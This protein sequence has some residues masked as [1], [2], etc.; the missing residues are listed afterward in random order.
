MPGGSSRTEPEVRY[1]WIPR[2]MEGLVNLSFCDKRFERGNTNNH[3]QIDVSPHNHSNVKE[4]NNQFVS[5]SVGF[6]EGQLKRS[7]RGARSLRPED[8]SRLRSIPRIP[9]PP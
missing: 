3:S 9:D 8:C 6:Q 7:K 1:D 5:A 4:L 2:E